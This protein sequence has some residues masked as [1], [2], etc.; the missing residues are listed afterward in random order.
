[1]SRVTLGE[2][3]HLA[4]SNEGG[5]GQRLMNSPDR[6]QS[7]TLQSLLKGSPAAWENFFRQYQ[8]LITSVVS[9]S[10]WRFDLHT[11]DDIA[12]QI[13][14]ELPRALAGYT[15]QSSLDYF[16]KRICIHRCV[17]EVRR[18]FKERQRFVPLD[19]E[20]GSSSHPVAGAEYDPIRQIILAERASALKRLLESMEPACHSVIKPFYLKNLSYKDLS[21]RLGISVNTV[22]SR[23]A[24][25]LEK[26]RLMI[27][28]DRAAREYFS[29]DF[30]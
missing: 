6:I 2:V 10:K 17:D 1:M 13:R 25:C 15:G 28:G 12:Q 21:Q 18:Q 3:R 23:L 27:E 11:R 5:C 24:R 16:I 8:P 7:D 4:G 30:D 19:S 9:W 26:L 29:S 20:N 14:M 22:G